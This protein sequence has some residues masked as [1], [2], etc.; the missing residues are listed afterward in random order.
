MRRKATIRSAFSLLEMV[1]ALA[2]GLVILT[3]LYFY[4]STYYTETDAGRSILDEGTIARN[5]MTKINSD[6]SGHLCARDPRVA[7]YPDF[8]TTSSSNASSTQTATTAPPYVKYNTSVYGQRTVLVLS[9]YHVQRSSVP[10]DQPDP[11]TISDMRRTVYWL[12]ADGPNCG[13]YRREINQATH[14]D[15]DATDPTSWSSSDQDLKNWLVAP[16]VFDGEL[17]YYTGSEKKGGGQA[18]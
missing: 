14:P 8:A 5:I 1:L 7:S 11:E 10:P 16:E 18:Q 12:V 13:L 15:I 3:A 17:K 2:L 6:V 9:T 4:L